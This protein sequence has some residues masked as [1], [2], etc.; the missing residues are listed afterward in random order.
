MPRTFGRSPSSIQSIW[1]A[2]I[3]QILQASR[4]LFSRVAL[5]NYYSFGEENLKNWMSHGLE[6]KASQPHHQQQNISQWRSIGNLQS[7]SRSSNWKQQHYH[8][9]VQQHHAGIYDKCVS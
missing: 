8:H 4:F 5:W 2:I 1:I 9:A 3:L 6:R 7:S